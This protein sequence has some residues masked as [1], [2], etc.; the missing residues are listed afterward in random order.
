M[1]EGEEA[2]KSWKRLSA[3]LTDANFKLWECSRHTITANVE[4][5]LTTNISG[6]YNKGLV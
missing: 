1:T 2:G 3:E 6:H 4:Q 5:D